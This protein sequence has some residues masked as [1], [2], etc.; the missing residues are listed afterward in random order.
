M[1]EGKLYAVT[2]LTTDGKLHGNPYDGETW[3]DSPVLIAD[4]LTNVA[5]DDRR[6]A[7]EFDPSLLWRHFNSRP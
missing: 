2:L 6:L 7:V 4:D 5:G 1:D 3:S